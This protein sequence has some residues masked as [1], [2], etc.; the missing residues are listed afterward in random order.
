MAIR[1]FK[2]LGAGARG[3]RRELRIGRKKKC[4]PLLLPV[5]RCAACSNVAVSRW[6]SSSGGLPPDE[7]NRYNLPDVRVACSRGENR[8]STYLSSNHAY[9]V[10]RATHDA[11]GESM[12]P[13]CYEMSAVLAVAFVAAAKTALV[14]RP[15]REIAMVEAPE[16]VDVHTSGRRRRERK[17]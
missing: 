6:I 5:T 7:K 9:A 11:R 8:V 15:V 16:G 14:V 13:H 10:D 1:I 4:S 12:P 3:A 17:R 2:I